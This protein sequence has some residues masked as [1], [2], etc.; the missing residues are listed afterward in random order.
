MDNKQT[1][2]KGVLILFITAI[3]WGTSFVAQSIGMEKIE[4]FT[5]NGIRT[6]MGA[7]FLLPVILIRL[8]AKRGQ[9]PISTYAKEVLM[10]NLNT[11]LPIF[12][13]K[14]FNPLMK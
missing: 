11:V 2:L 5:Y 1:S 7:M 9:T 6:V 10:K 14:R 13:K 12:F 8:A 4:A 3:I